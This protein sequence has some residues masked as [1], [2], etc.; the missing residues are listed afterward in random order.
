MKEG[1]KINFKVEKGIVK[2][3]K[4]KLSRT[5]VQHKYFCPK[6]KKANKKIKEKLLLILSGSVIGLLNGFFGGGGGMVCVPILEKVLKLNNKQA[7]ASAIAVIFP[8]SLISA[9]IYVLNGYI[10]SLPLVSVGAGV[11]LGGILGS[12]ALKVMPPK[13]I[14]VIFAIIMFI[15]GIKLIL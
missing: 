6:R 11:V 10:S 7:H 2:E 12:Y 9:F 15:G 3:D 14:R 4:P 1:K 13:A 8:L 5:L